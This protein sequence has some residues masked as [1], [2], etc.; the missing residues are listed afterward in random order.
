MCLWEGL[1]NELEDIRGEIKEKSWLL[2]SSDTRIA[3]L[4]KSP[5]LLLSGKKT[6]LKAS[7]I[8]ISQDIRYAKR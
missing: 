5:I 8:V 1:E 6:R 4:C 7:F 3:N 2:D